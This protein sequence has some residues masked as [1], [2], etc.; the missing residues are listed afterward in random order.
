MEWDP[1]QWGQVGLRGPQG[2]LRRKAGPNSPH[3]LCHCLIRILLSLAALEALLSRQEE[4]PIN[5]F[6]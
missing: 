3:L 4:E 1:S 6:T 5:K 2:T